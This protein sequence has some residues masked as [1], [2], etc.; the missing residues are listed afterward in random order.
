MTRLSFFLFASLL[1]A[2]G[3]SRSGTEGSSK[4]EIS[5]PPHP[6]INQK[7]ANLHPQ[8]SEPNFCY[9]IN[10][11][12][13]G[14]TAT[15]DSCAPTAGVRTPFLRPLSTAMIE[16]PRGL[17]RTLELYGYI[18]QANETCD[19]SGID[20]QMVALNRLFRLARTEHIDTTPDEVIVRLVVQYSGVNNHAG[21]QLGKNATCYSGLPPIVVPGALPVADVLKGTQFQLSGNISGGQRPNSQ[22]GSNFKVD[23]EVVYAH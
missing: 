11:I 8:A 17:E 1:V 18:P 5:L 15:E 2:T 3:C 9:L 12:G 23:Y 4:I 14:I 21:I 10:V 6:S 22:K 13:E 20:L 7:S 16:V 19:S